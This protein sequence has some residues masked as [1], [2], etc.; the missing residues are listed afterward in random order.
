VVQA[1]PVPVFDANCRVASIVLD[2]VLAAISDK[3]WRHTAGSSSRLDDLANA[4]P[5][6]HATTNTTTAAAT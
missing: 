3:P 6:R 2:A 1:G 5:N 4:G